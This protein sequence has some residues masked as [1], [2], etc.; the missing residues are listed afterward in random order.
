MFYQ[1]TARIVRAHTAEDVPTFFLNSQ[2]QC[3]TGSEHACEIACKIVDPTGKLRVS[4]HVT[5]E[6]EGD[7]HR[8]MYK[9]FDR[10]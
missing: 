1:V 8:P 6:L 2:V 9:M 7:G 3:I 5:P 10:F 4:V